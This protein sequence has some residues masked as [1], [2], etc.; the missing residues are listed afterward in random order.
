MSSVDKWSGASLLV[1][2]DIAGALHCYVYSA[3]PSPSLRHLWT[4]HLDASNAESPAVSGSGDEDS[5]EGC[6][7]SR[8][9]G[10]DAAKTKNDASGASRFQCLISKRLSRLQAPLLVASSGT[11]TAATASCRP[12]CS[13]AESQR[14]TGQRFTAS[15]PVDANIFE[16]VSTSTTDNQSSLL[17]LPTLT[18]NC[19]SC[20]TQPSSTTTSAKTPL[21]SMEQPPQQQQQQQQRKS[22]TN[23]KRA[24][25]GCGGLVTSSPAVCPFCASASLVSSAFTT[26]DSASVT[27]ASISP[28]LSPTATTGSKKQRAASLQDS[29]TSAHTAF[30]CCSDFMARMPDLSLPAA[31]PTESSIVTLRK[32]EDGSCPSTPVHEAMR[33]AS[34]T[35]TAPAAATTASGEISWYWRC[36]DSVLHGPAREDGSENKGQSAPHTWV[37]L[38]EAVR[39]WNRSCCRRHRLL[40]LRKM[41]ESYGEINLLTGESMNTAGL[42]TDLFAA[43]PLDL[44]D[45]ALSSISTTGCA[46]VS[47]CE[48]DSDKAS[49]SDISSSVQCSAGPT[50]VLSLTVQ[51]YHTFLVQSPSPVLSVKRHTKNRRGKRAAK[52]TCTSAAASPTCLVKLDAPTVHFAVTWCPLETSTSNTTATQSE[53]ND[54]EEEKGQALAGFTGSSSTAV[55]RASS[56]TTHGDREASRSRSHHSSTSAS[57]I[58]ADVLSGRKRLPLRYPFMRV[59]SHETAESTTSSS[60]ST[61]FASSAPSSAWHRNPKASHH[62]S[63]EEEEKRK[64][65]REAVAVDVPLRCGRRGEV[66]VVTRTPAGH[67]VDSDSDSDGD[68]EERQTALQPILR[69]PAPLVQA[70]WVCLPTS[71]SSTAVNAARDDGEGDGVP[72]RERSGT[73]GAVSVS[74]PVVMR[75]IPWVPEHACAL[76][77]LVAGLPATRSAATQGLPNAA[78]ASS[79]LCGFLLQASAADNRLA[80]LSPSVAGCPQVLRPLSALDMFYAAATHSESDD[81]SH[82]SLL[83]LESNFVNGEHVD[84]AVLSHRGPRKNG[85]SAAEKGDHHCGYGCD[86][87]ARSRLERGSQRGFPSSAAMHSRSSTSSLVGEGSV[88]QRIAPSPPH[89][90]PAT[91]FFDE[92]FEPLTI[93]GRGVGGAVL[94]AR[95]RVTGVFYAVKVLVARDYESERDILQEVRVHAMLENKYVVRY[96]ACWSEVITATR[97]QQL[98]FIGVCH[99]HEANLPRR[100]RLTAAATP[101]SARHGRGMGDDRNHYNFNSS[102]SL[103]DRPPR[104]PHKLWQTSSQTQFEETE[105][106]RRAGARPRLRNAPGGW[107]R[108]VLPTSHSSMLLIGSESASESASPVATVRRPGPALRHARWSTATVNEYVGEDED[109]EEKGEEEEQVAGAGSSSNSNSGESDGDTA[110]ESGECSEHG[111]DHNIIGSRVVFLQMEFCQVTLAQHLSSRFSISRVENLLILLQIVAGL[112]YLHSRGLLHRDLKPT[113]VFMDYRCQYDKV[114]HGPNSS[115]TSSYSSDGEADSDDRANDMW[116]TSSMTSLRQAGS[117]LRGGNGG[118]G[119]GGGAAAAIASSRNSSWG[120]EPSSVDASLCTALTLPRQRRFLPASSFSHSN[121]GVT[122]A[123]RNGDRL[124]GVHPA[125]DPVTLQLNASNVTLDNLPTWNGGRSTLDVVLHTAHKDASTLLQG[126]LARRPPPHPPGNR[127]GGPAPAPGKDAAGRALIQYQAGKTYL[128]H[129]ANWLCHHFVQV[130]LGDFGL[131]KFL[132]QQDV[133]VDGFVSMN[134]ANTIGVGSPLYASPEQLKGNRCTPAS[135]AFSVGIMMAEMYLQ[136]TTI[137]ERLTVLREVRDGVYQDG[138]LISRYPELKLVH[139]LTLAQPERRITLA[140]TQ[141]ALKAA[142]L[143][144]LQDEVA[145]DYT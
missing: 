46:T 36:P 135:D 145:R 125:V 131:A 93:L 87:N 51:C 60:A 129:L 134:A 120:E 72:A 31:L 28:Q 92:N 37:P 62:R 113:N 122:C 99:P 81:Y 64:S 80:S 115:S 17:T 116:A 53:K 128:R 61:T 138:A 33:T 139:Q 16:D 39:L 7:R 118:G 5:E 106:S 24:T 1:A 140:A 40:L 112:R 143:K 71:S 52:A 114:V 10:G 96:H 111:E 121:G 94:L 103:R 27:T 30:F 107:D 9:S 32:T 54:E 47:S 8:R 73:R 137:A 119:G 109:G 38:P 68:S 59:A 15:T 130:R 29:P 57:D 26:D 85:K 25:G 77:M 70:V 4:R 6:S 55:P 58:D 88:T 44:I 127:H 63:T 12:P 84:A 101:T 89:F 91:S 45:D 43:A 56:A 22:Q 13:P 104:V 123:T 66:Y 49:P 42:A 141:T 124:S 23:G 117:S 83:T 105:Q 14:G 3:E 86:G 19:V 126:R 79:T 144:A 108:L 97:A 78:T 100:R 67:K 2:T 69:L 102:S 41:E 95:H 11:S 136:P 50:A 132:F 20:D 82:R 65:T 48:S 35:D 76:H 18:G 75:A 98:A 110:R 142:L 74:F 133:R 90:V 21:N 34:A